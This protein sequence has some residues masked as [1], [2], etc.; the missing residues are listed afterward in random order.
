VADP[1]GPFAD[2]LVQTA[3]FGFG[4]IALNPAQEPL[5]DPKIREALSLVFPRAEIAGILFNGWVEP[6]DSVL[7]DGMLGQDWPA[8][9]P[10]QDLD[11]AREAIAGSR[12]GRA[13]EVPPIRIYATGAVAGEAL[14]AVAREELGLEIEVFDL[15]W[16]DFLDR[17]DS[18]TLPA[19]E[20][21]WAADFPDPEAILLALWGSG[22]PDNYFGYSN[23][24]FDALLA[25]AAEETDPEQRAD[26]YSRASQVLADDNVVIPVYMDVQYTVVKPWVHNLVITPIGILR[27][28]TVQLDS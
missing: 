19:F 6:A 11:A 4:Y 24:E 27:L 14:R 12:Y 26:L 25:E 3:Q 9:V 17:L 15:D 10:D 8:V 21:Y 18:G 28:E 13:A 23:P 20:L 2:E 22:Q 7:P 5:D 1:E 16:F